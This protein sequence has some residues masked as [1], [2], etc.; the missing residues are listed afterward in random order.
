M[1]LSFLGQR[2]ITL[3]DAGLPLSPVESLL[4]AVPAPRT[5]RRGSRAAERVV[6]VGVAHGGS[7]VGDGSACGASPGPLSVMSWSPLP[8]AR[9]GCP[10]RT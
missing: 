2:K 8:S 3:K 5:L 9:A 7:A 6:A 4:S 10:V 1:K